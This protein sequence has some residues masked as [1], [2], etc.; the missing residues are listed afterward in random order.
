MVYTCMCISVYTSMHPRGVSAHRRNVLYNMQHTM[1][2]SQ[3]HLGPVS[4]QLMAALSVLQSLTKLADSSIGCRAVAEEGV[5]IVVQS[6]G[7]CEPLDGLEEVS[8]LPSRRLVH[9]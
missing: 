1:Y 3:P 7:L 4:L 2:L 6:D 9:G 8:L 5:V